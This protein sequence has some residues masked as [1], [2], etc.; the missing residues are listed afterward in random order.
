MKTANTVLGSLE[1]SLINLI[2]QPAKKR[3]TLVNRPADQNENKVNYENKKEIPKSVDCLWTMANLAT[4]LQ[5]KQSVIRYWVNCSDL[6]HIKIGKHLRFD[7]AD[8]NVWISDHKNK[9]RQIDSEFKK[10]M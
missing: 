3:T 6:P 2:E 7:P 5:V 8:I 10:I 4:Y 1:S 9:N